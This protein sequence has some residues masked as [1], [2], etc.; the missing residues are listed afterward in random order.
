M[1]R[2]VLEER[3]AALKEK[4][5]ALEDRVLNFLMSDRFTFTYILII[6]TLGVTYFIRVFSDIG[7]DRTTRCIESTVLW[8][9]TFKYYVT[10]RLYP[11]SRSVRW[12][13]RILFIVSVMSTIYWILG[14]PGPR[15][16]WKDW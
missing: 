12:W 14:M 6:L 16:P 5:N 2:D 4:K 15:L 10:K 8:L 13:F 11:D 1:K 9:S 7:F 3:D